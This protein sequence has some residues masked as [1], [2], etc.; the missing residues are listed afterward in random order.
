MA[1]RELVLPLLELMKSLHH[2]GGDDVSMLFILEGRG[3]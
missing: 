3:L 1:Y 2:L